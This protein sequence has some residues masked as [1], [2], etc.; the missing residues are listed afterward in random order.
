MT[1]INYCKFCCLNICLSVRFCMCACG[2]KTPFCIYFFSRSLQ[3][4]ITFIF[5]K[6]LGALFFSFIYFYRKQKIIL[7]FF[8]WFLLVQ[9]R[10]DEFRCQR[11]GCIA[12]SAVCDS[13][14]DCD[15]MSDE[16]PSN[17]P[18]TYY[19]FHLI[20]FLF[21]HSTKSFD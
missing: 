8:A 21:I 1:S 4:K 3:I 7:L 6:W 14:P 13:I 18:G 9:C 16:L 20:I 17:C 10:P 12:L 11:G 5:S 2:K 19:F 15:D